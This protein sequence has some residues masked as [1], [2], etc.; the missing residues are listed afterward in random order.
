MKW[1]ECRN[2]PYFDHVPYNLSRLFHPLIPGLCRSLSTDLH[3]DFLVLT[4]H[5]QY[6]WFPGLFVNKVLY[7]L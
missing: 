5:K 4:Q 1:K 7:L 2:I 6:G 3:L